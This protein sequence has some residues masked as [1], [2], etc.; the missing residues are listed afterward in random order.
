MKPI[1]IYVV[2]AM[3]LGQAFGACSSKYT[4]SLEGTE[5]L[6]DS[7]AIL[8]QQIN[9]ANEKLDRILQKQMDAGTRPQTEDVNWYA[10]LPKTKSK[11][12]TAKLP[13]TIY[14]RLPVD[15][16]IPGNGTSAH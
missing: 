10:T 1:I 7:V 14:V 5:A 13:V 16:T 12:D 3:L 2:A 6:A 11:Y 8:H 15:S 4:D 9:A